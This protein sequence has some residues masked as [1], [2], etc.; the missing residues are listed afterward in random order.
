MCRGWWASLEEESFL[1]YWARNFGQIH[2]ILIKKEDIAMKNQAWHYHD[3]PHIVIVCQ[4]LIPLLLLAV[5]IYPSKHESPSITWT[6]LTGA[7][8]IAHL[9]H[10]RYVHVLEASRNF[11]SSLQCTRQAQLNRNISLF[12]CLWGK[13][14][15]TEAGRR[16]KGEKRARSLIS[17]NG[18]GFLGLL[19]SLL[20]EQQNWHWIWFQCPLH[21]VA[22][23]TNWATEQWCWKGCCNEF[24]RV[25]TLEP[26]LHWKERW[27]DSDSTPIHKIVCVFLSVPQLTAVL[28]C[29][30]LQ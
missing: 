10:T 28:H 7:R 21:W 6:Y 12:L 4:L 5:S 23:S 15:S 16:E 3:H 2:F 1:C 13:L 24:S 14:E 11:Q 8:G 27:V 22:L 30:L 25:K 9:C 18:Q 19:C 17:L 20:R 26:S 29:S